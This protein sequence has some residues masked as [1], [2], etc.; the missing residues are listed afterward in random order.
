MNTPISDFLEKYTTSGALRLHMPGHNGATPHDIT[1]IEGA[2]S[3]YETDRTK[4]IIGES[5]KNAAELFGADRTC[6]SCGGSTLAI[7]AALAILKSQG[8]KTIAASRYSHKSL[9]SAAALLHMNVKWLY[10]EEY[11]SADV[12]YSGSALDGCDAVFMT[13]IDYLGGVCRLPNTKLPVVCDNAHGAYLKFVDKTKFGEKYLHP[14]EFGF[15]VMSAESAHKTLPVLTGGAYLHFAGGADFTR[16]KE[17]MA[18]FGSSSPS[19]LMLESLDK[20]NKFITE[21]PDAVNFACEAVANLKRKLEGFEIPIKESDPLRVVV[22]AY[23]YGYNGFNYADKLRQNGVECEMS[24]RN[25]AVLLFSAATTH[26][27]CQRALT[28]MSLIPQ[29]KPI[30]KAV[31][32]VLKPKAALPAYDAMFMP[33]KKVPLAKAIGFVC[34]GIIAPCPPCVP[35]VMPGEIISDEAAEA[36]RLYN[37]KE[38]AVI[39]KVR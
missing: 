32:P 36:L 1:E 39:T 12:D 9:I 3:L 18:A 33:Q 28:A 23:E 19:Y 20:F 25:H 35:L 17:M 30:P 26:R 27:D 29:K 37:V 2:D 6:Y 13:N 24:D 21:R 38:V 22:N 11:L 8:C 7:Q 31:Y 5:E 4:S 14:T 10:P 34:G 16:A 15:P